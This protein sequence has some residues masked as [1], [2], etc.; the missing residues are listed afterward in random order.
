SQ[1]DVGAHFWVE[2]PQE[3]VAQTEVQ[4]NETITENSTAIKDL[5]TILYIED[6]PANLKL[7]CKIL[8]KQQHIKLITAHEPEL[9][10]ELAVTHRP[11]LI[12]MDINMPRMNGY[13]ML[14]IFQSD[15]QLKDIPIIAITANAM[16][17]D[18]K[19][20]KE[21]GFSDYLS[22]PLDIRHFLTTIEHHL[23]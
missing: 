3:S 17:K 7:V 6:N 10:L 9:G 19:R 14:S 21:A 4:D 5:K 18:I 16:A 11:K 23:A 20:G 1:L 8:D 22:K 15:E 13:Q 2:L 12:L